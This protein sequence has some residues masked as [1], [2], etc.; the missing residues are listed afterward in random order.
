MKNSFDTSTVKKATLHEHI[1]GTVTP[2]MAVKLA[3]RHQVK[4][5]EGF[6][7]AEGQY[8]KN[9]F[10]NGR[11][12][13]NESE[14]GEFITTYDTAAALMK[15]PQ[16][17]Y[18]VTKDY[19]TKNANA[20]GV[21]VEMILSPWHMSTTKN[22]ETGKDQLD[23]K[24]HAQMMGAITKAVEECKEEYGIETR[25]IATGVRNMGKEAVMEV[26]KFVH[27]NPHPLITG[28]GIAGDERAGEFDDFADA[29][30]LAKASGLKLAVHAGEIRGPKSIS[31]AIRLGA[32]RVGHGVSAVQDDQVMKDLAEKKIM[33]EVC[34][35]SN[36]ILVNDLKGDLA[37]HP[38]RKLYDAGIQ[39]SI[40]PDDAGIFGTNTA[41]EHR[42]SN[43]AFGF[44]KA[45]MT[46]ITLCAVDCSFADVK[47]K[48]QVKENIYKSM[49]AEDRKEMAEL[50]ANAK[51]P[52]LKE[53][54]DSRVK[55]SERV[56]KKMRIEEMKGKALKSSKSSNLA[57]AKRLKDN[58]SR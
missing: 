28:F 17:Y 16:D 22:P 50:A 47:T 18:D 55:E 13:Y 48:K 15:T 8:D 26:A 14:F 5:P 32:S 2:E 34:P 56:A 21:Y 10:P 57:L 49:S 3:N 31:D 38:A 23:A 41:K 45:E 19:L 4:L 9:D 11:Y 29:L 46:D 52:I 25:F 44:T 42:V 24:K 7:M 39:I 37:N 1:E 40:N 54:L 27:D 58:K 12:A 30:A 51:N 35:T 43:N 53:R 6:I 20:G 36:R 33:V